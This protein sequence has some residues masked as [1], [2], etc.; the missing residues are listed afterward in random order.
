MYYDAIPG[1]V[2]IEELVDAARNV[3]VETSKRHGA[4]EKVPIEECWRNTGMAPV[5]GSNGLTRTKATRRT[6]SSGAGW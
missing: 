1:E 4:Y 6:P 5:W 3:E 2:M